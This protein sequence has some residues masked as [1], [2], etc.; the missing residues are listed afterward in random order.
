MDLMLDL[1]TARRTLLDAATDRGSMS[2]SVAATLEMLV[3]RRERAD[4]L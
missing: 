3:A 4:L 1:Q 2:P